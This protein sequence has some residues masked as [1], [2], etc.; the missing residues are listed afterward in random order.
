M[1]SVDLL[2]SRLEGVT[3]TPGGSYKARCPAHQDK[4]PSLTVKETP[5]GVVL[6]KCWAGCTAAEVVSAAGLDM[7]DLFPP[8]AADPRLVGKPVRRPFP[9]TD[10]LR[11]I[12]FEALIV[13]C[14][15]ATLAAGEPLAL[16]DRERLMLAVSRI[17]EALQAGGLNHG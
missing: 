16:I 7:V 3:R 5:D 1:M 11:T 12:A 9:A 17:Q 8:R 13:G 10:I 4:H 15:A 14:A 6:I 2:L